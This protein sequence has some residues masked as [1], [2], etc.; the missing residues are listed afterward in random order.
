MPNAIVPC[1]YCGTDLNI[2]VK[3]GQVLV[4]QSGPAIEECAVNRKRVENGEVPLP[5][6]ECPYVDATAEKYAAERDSSGQ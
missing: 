6:Q 5:I 3:G 4:T 1:V 2:V